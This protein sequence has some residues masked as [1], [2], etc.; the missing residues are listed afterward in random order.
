M[1]STKVTL[2]LDEETYKKLK[3][4]VESRHTTMSQWVTD[5]IWEYDRKTRIEDMTQMFQIL[6]TG[7]NS[8]PL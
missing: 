6:S 7:L 4:I 5:E 8:K 3:E 1:G 2:S